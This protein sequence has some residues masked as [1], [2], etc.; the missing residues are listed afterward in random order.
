MRELIAFFAAYQDHIGAWLPEMLAAVLGTLKL[1]ALSFMLALAI[2]LALAIMRLSRFGSLK[3]AA[4]L[5]IETIRGTP[6]LVI[7]AILYF[8]LPSLNVSWLVLSSFTAAV[9]GLGLHG[10]A[11]TAEIFR[12]GIQALH[13]GQREAALATGMTPGQ[14]MRWILLPQ[15]VLIV[16]PPLGNFLIGLLK[17][18][19]ICS[20]IA[21]P[22]LMLRAKDLS[23]TYFM[24]MHL[25]VLAAA[26]Y[27]VMSYPL[28]VLVRRLERKLSRGRA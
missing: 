22:D 11:F 17:D 7:L 20:I 10:G 27:L 6:P 2:G 21:A 9:L 28:S 1:T 25:Y 3:A 5:Y 4:G 24:P 18:T 8:G 19:A 14:A 13:K 23:S 15:A 26:L 12:A 16:V